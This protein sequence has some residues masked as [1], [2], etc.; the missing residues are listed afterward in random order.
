MGIECPTCEKKD[1]GSPSSHK[2][3][4]TAKSLMEDEDEDDDEEEPSRA[5]SLVVVGGRKDWSSHQNGRHKGL[6]H[7]NNATTTSETRD[8]ISDHAMHCEP[9]I[10]PLCQGGMPMFP[11]CQGNALAEQIDMMTQ[12]RHPL[13]LFSMFHDPRVSHDDAVDHLL[14]GMHEL[15]RTCEYCGASDTDLCP[16]QCQRPK[17][18]FRKKRPPFCPPDS[19]IW[20]PVTDFETTRP[21]DAKPK[22]G[23]DHPLH[24]VEEP[25]SFF[26]FGDLF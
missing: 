21:P 8:A 23:E 5:P 15:P 6:L 10:V 3:S 12:C 4:L 11:S 2:L 14:P 19:T 13:E 17:S 16:P 18:F 9:S 7:S 1:N 20:D 26:K 25:A 22:E 24:V